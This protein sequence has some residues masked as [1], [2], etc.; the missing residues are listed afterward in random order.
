MALSSSR[1]E[2]SCR[3]GIKLKGRSGVLE[4]WFAWESSLKFTPSV[5]ESVPCTLGLRGFIG[6]SDSSV[7]RQ[8]VIPHPPLSSHKF[9]S[10][11]VCVL[12]WNEVACKRIRVLHPGQCPLCCSLLALNSWECITALFLLCQRY[13]IKASAGLLSCINDFFKSSTDNM[14][15]YILSC[16]F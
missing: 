16:D 10:E 8:S 11:L 3:G 15:Q 12:M 13:S 2:G 1:W 7:H 9:S 4:N 5:T 14:L 6:E